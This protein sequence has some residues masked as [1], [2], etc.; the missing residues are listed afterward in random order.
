MIRTRSLRQGIPS[1]G[2]ATA[3]F[4]RRR[5]LADAHQGLESYEG[6]SCESCHTDAARNIHTTRANL[7]CRQCHG[8]EPIASTE[9]YWSPMNP[10]RRHAYVCSKCHEGANASYAT[11]VVH[12]PFPALAST[13][14]SFPV[15]AY[16]FWIMVGSAVVTFALFLPHTVLWGI[17]ELFEKKENSNREPEEQHSD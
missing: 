4:R 12:E 7:T 2:T 15:L 8:A 13:F 10:I 6:R 17:R 5:P 1:H 11:Y 3:I 16:A 14:G 9:H